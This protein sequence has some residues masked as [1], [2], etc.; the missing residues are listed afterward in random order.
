[1]YDFIN[2]ADTRSIETSNGEVLLLLRHSNYAC[3]WSWKW[4]ASS[5]DKKCCFIDWSDGIGWLTGFTSH[6][7]AGPTILTLQYDVVSSLVQRSE[8]CLQLMTPAPLHPQSRAQV[9]GPRLISRQV[10]TPVPEHTS[11]Y[12]GGGGW[13]A[14]ACATRKTRLS[15]VVSIFVVVSVSLL[16]LNR[17]M[18]EKWS[19]DQTRAW[20]DGR[21]ALLIVLTETC[22]NDEYFACKQS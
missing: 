3:I 9:V 4:S 14:R 8:A 2:D 16:W 7:H 12:S 13:V 15:D 17:V 1:M 5:N 18:F 11:L 20:I 21:E 19:F 22:R 6:W 10:I